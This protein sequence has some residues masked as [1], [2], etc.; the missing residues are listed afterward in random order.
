MIDFIH[1]Q[2]KKAFLHKIFKISG[3]FSNFL[4]KN[5]IDLLWNKEGFFFDF[6]RKKILEFF[7][8]SA[9][10]FFVFF[11]NLFFFLKNFLWNKTE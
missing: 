11:Q 6:D 7:R 5:W 3:F 10:Y 4:F 9:D 1:T 2:L 8:I